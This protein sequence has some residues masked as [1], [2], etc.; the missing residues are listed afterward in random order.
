MGLGGTGASGNFPHGLS[1]QNKLLRA[2]ERHQLSAALPEGSALDELYPRHGGA[3]GA[4]DTDITS[5]K[6][7]NQSS[8]EPPGPVGPA[9]A[10]AGGRGGR[11]LCAPVA[12]P[13]PHPPTMGPPTRRPGLL[14]EQ[15]GCWAVNTGRGDD[16]EAWNQGLTPRRLV[17]VESRVRARPPG[18]LPEGAAGRAPVWLASPRVKA[19]PGDITDMLGASIRGKSAKSSER[20]VNRHCVK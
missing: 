11:R 12:R 3:S 6:G 14:W 16:R 8:A 9:P 4:R 17:P 19:R 2:N 5:G 18:L 15:G 10:L 1:P 13:P 20:S 7:R